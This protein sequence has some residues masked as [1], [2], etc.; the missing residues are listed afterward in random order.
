MSNYNFSHITVLVCDD[1]HYIRMLLRSF[2]TGFGVGKVLEATNAREGFLEF[3]SEDPDIVISDWNMGETNGIDLV[4]MIRWSEKSP[5]PFV[6]IIMLTGYTEIERI[7]QARD[8]G[9]SGYLAK[10]LT[11]ASL[12]KQLRA[13]SDDRRSFIRDDDFFGPDRRTRSNDEYEGSDRR[14]AA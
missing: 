1:S 6:P 14:Q 5:N 4:H 9:I 11:A 7:K 13:A 2:L 10:P 3:I 8:A 12:Y